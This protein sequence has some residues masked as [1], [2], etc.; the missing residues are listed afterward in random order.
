MTHRSHEIGGSNEAR[1]TS[2]PES[3]E[4]A[5]NRDIVRIYPNGIEPARMVIAPYLGSDD[6]QDDSR[7][8]KIFSDT[9]VGFR[10]PRVKIEYRRHQVELSSDARFVLNALTAHRHR[11][12]ASREILEFGGGFREGLLYPDTPIPNAVAVQF[13]RAVQALDWYSRDAT[14]RLLVIRSSWGSGPHVTYGLAPDIAIIDARTK[15]AQG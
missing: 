10:G 8:L 1:P 2:E 12:Q 4:P 5:A 11:L 9:F 14:D 15:H 7:I 13:S 6:L 3:Y